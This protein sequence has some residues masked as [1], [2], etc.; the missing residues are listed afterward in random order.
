M[1]TT[2]SQKFESWN[3]KHD[4]VLKNF[5][6]LSYF[7]LGVYGE[8]TFTYLYSLFKSLSPKVFSFFCL[9]IAYY[10]I[11][12]ISQA[13]SSPNQCNNKQDASQR[14]LEDKDET[15]QDAPKDI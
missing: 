4:I 7:I 8:R 10:G 6:S 5:I 2:L 14:K 3:K 1:K 15:E 11:R 9:V 12:K 13:I